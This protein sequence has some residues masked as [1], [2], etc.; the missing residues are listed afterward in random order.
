MMRKTAFPPVAGV[1]AGVLILGS[2]PGEE[3]LRRHEYYGHPRNAF[4]PIMGELLG[5]D[6]ALPYSER[7]QR[8]VGSKVA[9]WDVL[10]AC[11]RDG[12]LDAD[13][14]GPEPN[15][16]TAFVREHSR[17]N[18]VYCNGQTAGRLLKKFFPALPAQLP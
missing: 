17:L 4:W 3:S 9:L 7:L 13:I 15:D 6:P 2:M 12:S 11:R 14:R 16:I 8:L 18:A 5:F 10:A 1:A